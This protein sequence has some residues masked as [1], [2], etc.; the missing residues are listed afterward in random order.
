MIPSPRVIRMNS[1]RNP[2][3]PPVRESQT[4]VQRGRNNAPLT[5]LYAAQPND[6]RLFTWDR[7]S[8]VLH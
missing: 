1:P 3:N 8:A 2:I 4:L 7:T 6:S 5:I